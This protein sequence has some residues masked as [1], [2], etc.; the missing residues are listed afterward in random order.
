M[1]GS[2]FAFPLPS[3]V[4]A[5][6]ICRCTDVAACIH[7]VWPCASCLVVSSVRGRQELVD[8]VVP[9]AA[10]GARVQLGFTLCYP[11]HTG[12]VQAIVLRPIFDKLWHTSRN[13]RTHIYTITWRWRHS[14]RPGKAY[15]RKAH[16]NRNCNDWHDHP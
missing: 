13:R 7:V 5:E 9:A 3:L 16:D 2:A 14:A 15:P 10:L 12:S 6:H 11:Q 1:Q 4:D 8:P